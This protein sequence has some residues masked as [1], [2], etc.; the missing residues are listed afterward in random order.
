MNRRYGIDLTE[1][2]G[3][4]VRIQEARVHT[5]AGELSELGVLETHA[6]CGTVLTNEISAEHRRIIRVE[7][8]QQS[9]P[10]HPRQRVL[11]DAEDRAGAHVR[12][13]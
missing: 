11:F 9:R 10:Q 5:V 3:F 1:Q 6:L 13:R 12:G 4:P 7:R 8:D 2:G